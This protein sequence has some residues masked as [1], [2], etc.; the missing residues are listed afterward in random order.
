MRRYVL[1]LLMF[2]GAALA[3]YAQIS[4]ATSRYDNQRDG[5]NLNETILTPANVNVDEFGKLF[6]QTVDGYVYAQ[7]LYVPNVSVPNLGTHN[8]LYIA[9]QHDSVYAFDADDNQGRNAS[10]LW[11]RSFINPKKGITTV[12]SGDQNCTDII[13]EMGI[14]S[15]PVIDTN[16]GTMYVV[17]RT[18]ENGSYFQRL[19]A[20]DI[21]SGKE[22]AG[23][24]VVIK[25]KVKGT[26]DGSVGENF[27]S[28][29]IRRGS[30]PACF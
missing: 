25:A 19:H 26:G 24:P 27:V 23:S 2:F 3:G 14:T 13:P 18:K 1:A 5:Q 20:L 7:P 28:T 12:S 4:V 6:A 17:A 30:V 16:S 11:R 8:V 15:T 22:R 21:T 10:A 9:T 29:L